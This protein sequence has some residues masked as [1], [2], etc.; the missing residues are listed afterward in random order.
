MPCGLCKGTG[1][2]VGM[3]GN[4]RESN[5]CLR[6]NGERSVK[7][8]QGELYIWRVV[9][10]SQ[11][12]YAKRSLY[13]WQEHAKRLNACAEFVEKGGDEIRESVIR[14][15]QSI[16][17]TLRSDI[18]YWEEELRRLDQVKPA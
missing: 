13:N 5:I 15:I 18:L 12:R 14:S 8:T 16:V 4:V 2:V 9:A 10:N 17:E 7:I 3:F 1:E 11:I 6:C